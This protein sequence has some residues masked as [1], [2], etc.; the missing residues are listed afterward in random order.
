MPDDP[1]IQQTEDVADKAAQQRFADLFDVR[2]VI[3]G[4]FAVYGAILLVAG[5]FASDEDVD[6]A[7]GLNANLWVGLA[8]LATAAIFFGWALAAP[9]GAQL[10][11]DDA[12]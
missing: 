6:R 5:L 7:Q 11:D 2:R 9:V 10:V 12:T 4:L 8:L 3:G 1:H